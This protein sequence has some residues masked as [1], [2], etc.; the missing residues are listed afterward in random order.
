MP[1]ES[2]S[3]ETSLVPSF[4]G[5]GVPRLTI[6]AG[7]NGLPFLKIQRYLR[8]LVGVLDFVVLWEVQHEETML[9]FFALKI[10]KNHIIYEKQT[11]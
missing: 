5:S 3:F 2:C 4:A 9:W 7:N 8:K 1:C 11:L 6:H 10:I